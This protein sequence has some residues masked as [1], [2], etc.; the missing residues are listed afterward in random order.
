K[1]SN[2]SSAQ[3]GPLP[4]ESNGDER[5]DRR[6]EDGADV[7]AGVEN[8]RRQR[9][10]TAREPFGDGLDRRRE[11]TRFAETERESCGEESGHRRRVLQPDDGEQGGGR[12]T[13][14]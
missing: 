9:A 5:H 10:L 6:C 2:P 13:E 1:E 14:R 4:A 12:R 3:K 7:R 8:P 11:V